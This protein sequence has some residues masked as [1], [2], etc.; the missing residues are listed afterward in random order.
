MARFDVYRLTDGGLVVDCQADFLADIGTRFIVPLMPLDDAPPAN[1][2]INPTFDLEGERLVL[3]TQFAAAIR[4][5]ELRSR[6]G[7]LDAEH[8]SV[9]GAIDVLI[10]TA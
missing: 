9:T 4:T 1:A 7:S 8:L 6:V 5:S 3:V 2:R 10:G